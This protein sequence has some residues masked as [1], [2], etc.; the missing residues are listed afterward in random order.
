MRK[1]PIIR[2]EFYEILNIPVMKHKKNKHLLLVL[3]DMN[4]KTGPGNNRYPE[5]IG[6]YG[7]GHINR[8]E[9]YLLDFAKENEL[10][11]TKTLFPHKL[12]HR[13]TWSSIERVN[14][15]NHSDGTIRRNP[16]RNQIDYI[17]SLKQCTG[18][19]TGLQIILW[20]FN[21]HR[22]QTCQNHSQT[23]LVEDEKTKK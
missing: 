18:I 13:T 11:L 6:K 19:C 20:N 5:N 15:H 8:N 7:K 1:N 23:K 22:P 17:S 3:C 4:A 21:K 16:Y 14:E 12:A 9:E 2:D 10:I